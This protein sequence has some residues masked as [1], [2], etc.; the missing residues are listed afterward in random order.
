MIE[1]VVTKLAVM[2]EKGATVLYGVAEYGTDCINFRVPYRMEE[3][4]RNDN[5]KIF[6]EELRETIARS[7]D[8]STW[9]VSMNDDVVL[10]KMLSWNDR[11]YAMGLV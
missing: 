9:K 3:L 2:P 10:G 8:I 4:M 11:F 5:H 1:A 6:L 7:F